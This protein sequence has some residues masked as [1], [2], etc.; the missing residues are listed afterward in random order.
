MD[1]FTPQKVVINYAWLL[2]TKYLT[3]PAARAADTMQICLGV[4]SEASLL[5]QQTH[6]QIV[7]DDK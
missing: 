1:P 3:C 6:G 7:I 5:R 2:P 4:D